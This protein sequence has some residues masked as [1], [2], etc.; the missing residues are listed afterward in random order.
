MR[1]SL[2]ALATLA[3]AFVVLTSAE[4]KKQ[5]G[6]VVSVVLLGATGDLARKYLWQAIFTLFVNNRASAVIRV[7]AGARDAPAKGAPK[8]AD[9][10]DT[11]L[12]CDAPDITV[13]LSDTVVCAAAVADFKQSWTYMQVKTDEDYARLDAALKETAGLLTE[14]GRLFYLSVPPF[15]Y[16]QISGMVKK[17]AMAP[18]PAWTRVVLEKP[19]GSDL[20]SAQVQQQPTTGKASR[21]PA[22]LSVCPCVCMYFGMS[23]SPFVCL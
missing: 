15:A 2:L 16:E 10:L 13:D 14:A 22:C 6:E 12:Q 7:V 20:A 8:V 5:P 17:N 21:L 23:I 3:T 9:F 11:R 4:E 19:F 18:A 1:V